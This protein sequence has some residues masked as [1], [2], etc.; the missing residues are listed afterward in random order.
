[1]KDF[2]LRH[3]QKNSG[4]TLLEIMLVVGIIGLLLGIVAYNMKGFLE[5]GEDT[6]VETDFH[7]MGLALSTYRMTA[8][9]YPT[10]SQGLKA[11]V[12]QPSS[13]PIPRK[14]HQL[15]EKL[16]KDPWEEPYI[17]QSPGSRNPSSYDIHSK[18]PDRQDGT[19]DDIW[20]SK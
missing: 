5:A 17:Y 14:W 8:G 16:N 10:T 11:L 12:E 1:M 3:T 4:F 6:R 7:N 18:G 19:A 13:E 20:S 9:T 2:P 15:L